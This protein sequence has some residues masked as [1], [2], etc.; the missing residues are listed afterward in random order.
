MNIAG[1]MA[2]VAQAVVLGIRVAG[3]CFIGEILW[4]GIGV[5]SIPWGFGLGWGLG[6][7]GVS[8]ILTHGT[9]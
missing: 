2:G 6:E 4:T 1:K 9:L 3:C 7:S 8:Q 5:L